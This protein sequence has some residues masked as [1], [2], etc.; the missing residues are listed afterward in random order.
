MEIAEFV[1]ILNSRSAVKAFSTAGNLTF[2]GNISV[3]AGPLGRNAEAAGATN[4]KCLAAIYS[5]SNTYGVFAGEILICTKRNCL[6]TVLVQTLYKGISIEGSYI[7]ERKDRNEKVTNL[8]AC[9]T[10]ALLTQ[11]LLQFYGRRI[12]AAE[13]LSGTV[14]PPAACGVLYR[15]LNNHVGVPS[16]ALNAQNDCY[17]PDES[18][19]SSTLPNRSPWPTPNNTVAATRK[20]SG[21]AINEKRMQSDMDKGP[22][23]DVNAIRDDTRNTTRQPGYSKGSF[24][25][26]TMVRATEKNATKPQTATALYDFTGQQ[27]GDLTFKKNDVIIISEATKGEDD[28]W[29]GR[30]YEHE[31]CVSRAHGLGKCPNSH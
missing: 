11:K 27:D 10:L 19:K 1:F 5:Y 18:S 15:A 4:A 16:T 28:W 3:A 6:L 31:G 24:A 2:G 20:D 14:Q 30:V 8:V 9:V 12:A 25:N 7:M 29:I 26:A 22:F 21:T 17:N 23:S 13:L